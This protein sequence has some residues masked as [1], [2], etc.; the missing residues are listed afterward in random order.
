M[1]P[2]FV[3]SISFS[4]EQFDFQWL[5]KSSPAV[6]STGSDFFRSRLERG[7]LLWPGGPPEQ[8]GMSLFKEE[9]FPELPLTLSLACRER[10]ER[11]FRFLGFVRTRAEM[12][13]AKSSPLRPPWVLRWSS[14]PPFIPAST[15]T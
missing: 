11:A 2:L 7:L 6:L 10:R 8:R 3:E 13:A 4:S 15:F 9:D 5:T 12:Q 14:S 1:S